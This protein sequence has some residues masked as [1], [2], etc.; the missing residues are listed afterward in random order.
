MENAKTINQLQDAVPLSDGDFLVVNQPEVFNQITMLPG[1][2]RKI[3]VVELANYV[4]RLRFQNRII[5][6]Y[7]NMSFQPS[8]Q[9]LED[10][11]LVPLKYQILLISDYQELCDFKWVGSGAN[12]T[13]DWWYKC[14]ANG[15]RNPNGIYMRVEDGRGMF[16]RGA[17]ANAIKKGANNTP[18][19]GNS[20]GAFKSDV[21]RAFTGEFGNST[22]NWTATLPGKVVI[23]Y[24]SPSFVLGNTAADA[25]NLRLRFVGNFG[26]ET[27]GASI[28]MLTCMSY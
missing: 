10:W 9:Q 26:T 8:Q 13:A 2:T 7:V 24:I 3:T 18:Y 12:A 5:G 4:E 1:A 17:G 23:G 19:D 28:S 20:I 21:T 6:A 25:D 22:N 27:A 14:D 15:A 11:R 16:Y